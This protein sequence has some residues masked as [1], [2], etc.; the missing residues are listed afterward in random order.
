MHSDKYQC[1]MGASC[2]YYQQTAVELAAQQDPYKKQKKRRKKAH[3][4]TRNI[5][6]ISRE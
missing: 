3:L 2:T 6:K 1:H 4:L 5:E